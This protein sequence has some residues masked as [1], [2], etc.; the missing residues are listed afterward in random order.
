MS[1]RGWQEV[2]DE[3]IG[4][5]NDGAWPPGTLLPAE[6]ALAVELGVARTTVNRALRGLAE[7]GLV[8]RKR[9]AGTVVAEHPP[10][11][12]VL[13][14]PVIRKEVE[15]QGKT[16]RHHLLL[17]EAAPAPAPISARLH[18]PARAPMLHLVALHLADKR[19]FLLED[20]WL[21]LAA[22][23][24]AE[25]VDFHATSPN[26]WLLAHVPYTTGDLSISAEPAGEDTADLLA[27]PEGAALL[28]LDRATWNDGRAITAVRLT[29]APGYKMRAAL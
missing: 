9:K 12:A 18:L 19:P 27:A 5:I 20:R 16:W 22:L 15:G 4:R 21:N 8:D 17:R 2:Q 13:T 14:I 25:D 23:P 26:E 10:A 29:Y 6:T 28:T 11:R 1:R 24:E 7:S 3:L